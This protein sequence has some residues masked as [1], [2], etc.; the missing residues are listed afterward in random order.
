MQKIVAAVSV[1]GVSAR[2]TQ[3]LTVALMGDDA[4]RRIV[5]WTKKRSDE[6]AGEWDAR[7]SGGPRD[8]AYVVVTHLGG[9]SGRMWQIRQR[10]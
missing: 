5:S 6:V 10:W 8:C 2:N 3:E 1:Y 4:T 9:R 7:Q